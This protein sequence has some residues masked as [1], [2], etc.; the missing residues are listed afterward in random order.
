MAAVGI[1]WRLAPGWTAPVGMRA[2]SPLPRPPGRAITD[3]LGEFAVRERTTGGR[4]EDGH[5]LTERGRLGDPDGAGHHRAV[6]LV[7]E[8]GAHL[9][10]DLLG[11]LGPGVVH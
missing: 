11:E 9:L 6:H 2:P 7:A 5:G 1:S 8:V 4:I 3:L 10:L